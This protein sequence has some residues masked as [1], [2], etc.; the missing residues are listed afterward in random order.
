V[1]QDQ[2][3]KDTSELRAAPK[4]FKEDCKVNWNRKV[5]DVHNL[6]RGL[7]PYPAAYTKLISPKGDNSI[8][9]IFKA[10]P[11]DGLDCSTT[12]NNLVPGNLVTDQRTFLNVICREGMIS[13]DEVQLE[14]KRRMKTVD[15]LR[16]FNVD[17][18]WKV[19]QTC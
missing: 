7:S 12:E 14:G 18:G 2:Y 9:K 10:S 19:D 11:I 16:G 1:P 3:T 17:N 4:I 8:L 6:I 5:I 13:L 15:F